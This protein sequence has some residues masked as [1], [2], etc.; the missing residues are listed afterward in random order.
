[1]RGKV[2]AAHIISTSLLAIESLT[3]FMI[4]IALWLNLF[5][6]VDPAKFVTFMMLLLPLTHGYSVFR[7]ALRAETIKRRS[8]NRYN[9]ARGNNS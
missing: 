6:E 5:S 1:M 3:I 8:R 7:Y 9:T 2:V 4:E